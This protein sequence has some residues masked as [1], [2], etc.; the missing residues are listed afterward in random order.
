MR[1]IVFALLLVLAGLV[2]AAAREEI[3][4]FAADIELRVDGSVLV[5]ETIDVNAEGIEI[6]RGIFRD[7]P[8]VML[9]D[10]GNRLRPSLDVVSVTRNGSE[11]PYRVERMGDFQRIW[12]GDSSAFVPRGQHRYVV[13]YTMSRMARHFADYDELYFNATGNYWIFPILSAVASVRLPEGAVVADV[14]GYTGR[15]GS[16]EQAVSISD[17]PAGRIIVRATRPLAAGEGLTV[18]VSMAKGV[19][20]EPEGVTQLAHWF[21][22]RQDVI[23][24]TGLVL[25]VLGYFSLAWNAVGRD[26]PKGTIIPLFHPPSGFSPALAHYVHNWGWRNAWTA[27]TAAAFSLGV[28]GLV[29][30]DNTESTLTLTTT[31]EEPREP[32]PPGEAVL[33]GFLRGRQSLTIGKAVGPLLAQKRAEFTNAIETENRHKWFR[34]HWGYSVLGFVLA[35]MA[36]VA[37][38]VIGY[39]EPAFLIL[40]AVI[41]IFLGIAVT[42]FRSAWAGGNKVQFLFVGIWIAGVGVNMVGGFGALSTNALVSTGLIAAVTIVAICILFT[43]LMRAPTVQGR[44]VMDE[45][46]GFKLYLDTAEKE[47]LNITNEPPMT[48]ERFER[49]LPYAVA[50][51]VEKPWTEHFEAELARNAVGDVAGDGYSPRW[52]RGASGTSF[53]PAEL[54]RSVSSTASAMSA[55]M[56][57]AQPSTSS[58]SGFGGGGRSGGGGGGGG[59]GGW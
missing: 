2:S 19:L 45:I 33:F 23:V 18:S 14:Q 21:E 29:T 52:Y 44:K 56:V 54:V 28:K 36:L 37:M 16:S 22:D 4:S 15:P 8:V 58:S 26:P 49:I 7:I 38:V 24:P 46:E 53:A 57:A 13:R 20:V 32:L 12:I 41:G 48:V 11:E 51:G 39:L 30:I 25:L 35:G 3:R 17:G 5:T 34:D 43:V 42:L 47:R 31:G 10:D 59:G 27:F 1:R 50:L 55:A 40:A 9:D 6:R